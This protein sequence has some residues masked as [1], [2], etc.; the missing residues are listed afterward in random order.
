[1]QDPQVTASNPRRPARG[2]RRSSRPWSLRF[3]IR[4]EPQILPSPQWVRT[5][6]RSGRGWSYSPTLGAFAGCARRA[7]R[8]VIARPG[9]RG[10][11]SAHGRLLRH[12]KVSP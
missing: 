2:L 12:V 11:D 4:R 1:M 10:V 7:A 9:L 5:S 8:L 3:S 6:Q